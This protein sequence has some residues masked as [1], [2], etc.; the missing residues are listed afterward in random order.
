MKRFFCVALVAL[1]MVTSVYALAE[2]E[3]KLTFMSWQP[4]LNFMNDVMLPETKEALPDLTVEPQILDWFGYWD[5]LTIE[6]GSGAGPD[7][8]T[9]D[10]AHMPTYAEYL[11]PLDELLAEYIGE[12][13]QESFADS[14]NSMLYVDVDP[15]KTIVVPSDMT[16]CWYLFYNKT[17]CDELGVALPDGSYGDL[18]RFVQDVTAADPAIIPVA[19]AAQENDNIGFLYSWLVS[20]VECGIMEKATKGEAS[21]SDEA[22]VTAFDQIKMMYDDGILDSRDFALGAYPGCDDA[23]KNRGA[24][25]YLTGQWNMGS[26][27]MGGDLSNTALENDEVGM[28]KL[29]NITGGDTVLQEYISMGYAIN[30]NCADPEAAFQVI[31]EWIRGDAGAAWANYMG[32]LPAWT[33]LSISEEQ[34]RTEEGKKTY[35]EVLN[36]L[37]TSQSVLRSTNVPAL[38]T[39]IGEQV[40]AVLLQGLSVEDALAQM[41]DTAEYERD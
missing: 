3:V 34:L 28:V 16:G 25:C 10:S 35:Q 15:D 36:S 12:N 31:L 6:L 7:I 33:E 17:L 9:M 14:A 2:G 30:K 23:F 41:E 24:A 29:D 32:C 8:M 22:F 38:D 11:L 4:N 26:Y 1:M 20:N 18:V 27:M 19:F 39:K 40:T 37:A 21:F 5:K 13:W